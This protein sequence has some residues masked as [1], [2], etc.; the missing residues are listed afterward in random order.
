[1][2][3]NDPFNTDNKFV[4]SHELLTLL[5]W[6]LDYEEKALIA[7]IK[8][9]VITGLK[10]DSSY[11]PAVF[12]EA[13][14][15][16]LAEDAHNTVAYF[17]NIMESHMVEIMHEQSIKRASEKNLL[18]AIDQLNTSDFDDETVQLCIA[19]ATNLPKDSKRTAKEALCKELLRNWN[20]QKNQV[21]N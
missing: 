2:F 11:N 21:V 7:L 19:K 18:P 4:L 9:A 5:I 15:E 3:M 10:N 20:P 6:V 8:K 17:F 14:H 16:E 1:M 12:N 13:R